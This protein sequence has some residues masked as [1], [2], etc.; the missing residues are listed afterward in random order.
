MDFSRSLICHGSRY[1]W[2]SV[3]ISPSP[4]LSLPYPISLSLGVY[5]LSSRTGHSIMSEIPLQS[6]LVPHRQHWT[7]PVSREETLAVR[8]PRSWHGPR[9]SGIDIVSTSVLILINTYYK[10]DPKP[11]LTGCIVQPRRSRMKPS[12]GCGDGCARALFAEADSRLYLDSLL[13]LDAEDLFRLLS[14]RQD[15]ILS[16]RTKF[17]NYQVSFNHCK[18]SEGARSSSTSFQ[19]QPWLWGGILPMPRRPNG[20][21]APE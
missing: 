13:F 6:R 19:T 8:E 17:C 11:G 1:M 18:L 14:C 3:P 9:I 15:R 2:D 12:T 5:S 10:A 16:H 20:P 4:S 7:V 21:K